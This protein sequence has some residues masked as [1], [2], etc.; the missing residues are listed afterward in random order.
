MDDNVAL[1]IDCLKEWAKLNPEHHYFEADDLFDQTKLSEKIT[2][3]D[4]GVAL[5]ILI[6]KKIFE[7]KYKLTSK[8]DLNNSVV[9]NDFAALRKWTDG[10]VDIDNKFH[11]VPV[12]GLRS[13]L[14]L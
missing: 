1:A 9:L 13:W 3:I 6:E 8:K 5:A 10:I 11:V 2:G 4:F 14:P 12:Y 7:R